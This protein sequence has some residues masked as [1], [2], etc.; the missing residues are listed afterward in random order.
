[1][2]SQDFKE[3]I[4]LLNKNKVEYLIVGGYAVGLQG[5]PRY[6]GDIDIWIRTNKV[7]SVMTVRI[8]LFRST[9]YSQLRNMFKI[10]KGEQLY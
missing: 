6:T 5:Y 3:F 2:F 10:L 8:L 4:A 7:N 9:G 1:M